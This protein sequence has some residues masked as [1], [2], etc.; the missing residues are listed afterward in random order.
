MDLQMVLASK[1]L[2]D[3]YKSPEAANLP[4]SSV[5]SDTVYVTSIE[6]VAML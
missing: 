6:P 1:G 5:Y 3:V 4:A 2:L